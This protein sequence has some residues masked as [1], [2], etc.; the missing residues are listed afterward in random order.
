M[1]GSCF[2]RAQRL[3]HDGPVLSLTSFRD[4]HNRDEGSA[5]TG[6]R[7]SQKEG[8]AVTG[9]AV[10]GPLGIIEFLLLPTSF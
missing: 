7:A 8:F 4:E 9:F 3:L 10:M 1:L 5:V 2:N 6:P